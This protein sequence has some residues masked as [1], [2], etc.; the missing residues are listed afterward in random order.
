MVQLERKQCR[1]CG[2]SKPL[3]AFP[4]QR[5]GRSGRHPLCKQCRATQ[6]RARYRRDRDRLLQDMRSD[7]RRRRRVRR[8]SLERKYGLDEVGLAAL[9]TRQ[10]G[11]CLVCAL[12][13]PLV[14]D[15]DHRTGEVR[16]LLCSTCNLAIGELGDH[17]PHLRSA[18]D[19]LRGP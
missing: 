3:A 16:G 14:V 2:A 18:A 11:L 4:L 1:E 13:R 10:H 15:H 12:A 17:A 19:Y 7:P 5:G 8:R 9:R 6:E